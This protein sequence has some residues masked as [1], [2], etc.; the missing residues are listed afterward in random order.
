MPVVGTEAA[1]ANGDSIGPWQKAW[2]SG[3]EYRQ[4]QGRAA[5]GVGVLADGLQLDNIDVIARV[6]PGHPL[7][8]L[9]EPQI[10]EARPEGRS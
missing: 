2:I 9:G 7:G 8:A 6:T 4:G 1:V 10:L 5:D 3:D